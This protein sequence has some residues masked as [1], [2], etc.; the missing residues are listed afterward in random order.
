M[1]KEIIII[2]G[3][4]IGLCTAYYL[5]KD[6]HKIT[7]IDQSNM[8]SGASYVNAGYIIP[9]H[10]ISMAAPGIITKGIKWMFNSE[11]PFYVKPR[12]DADFL[13]WVL[14]FKKSAT[15]ERVGQ[16]ISALKNINL[17]SRDLY[18]D[19]KQSGDFNFHYERKGLLMCYKSNKVGEEEWEIGKRG[20]KEGLGVKHLSAKE[21]KVLEPK[22]NLNIKGAIYYD[23]D[24]HM[25]PNHFMNDM[26]TYLKSKGVVFYTNEKVNELEVFNDKIV[27][28]LTDK[29]ALIPDEVILTAGSWSPLITK[30]LGIKIP[31]QAGKGYRINVEQETKITIPSILCEAKVA[32]T[33]MDGFTRFAGT[34]EIAGINHN[35]NPKR[36][37]SIANAAQRYYNNLEIT[38]EEKKMA[39][40]GLRPVSPDGIPYIGKSSKCK[41]LTIATGHAMM[42]W[43]LGP[44][45]GKLVSEIISDKKSS[46]DISCYHPD[47]KF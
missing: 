40:C 3:G 36:V 20:I 38:L 18:E 7:V 8:D 45:T 41:N 27:K 6:G 19:M 32:V 22:A 24:G 39:E 37:N 14:A 25:T 15:K 1:E 2:G 4:I 35:I 16:S 42:G 34:M 46:L 5:R 29:R 12:L 10:F 23:C 21:V 33:P 28:V 31:V 9:S 30:K 44:A 13:K 47:R 43:S 11:S 17:F 26:A